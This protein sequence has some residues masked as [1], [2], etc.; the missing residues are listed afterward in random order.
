MASKNNV[1]SA[2]HAAFLE[3]LADLGHFQLLVRWQLRL[4]KDSVGRSLM[5]LEKQG[6]PNQFGAAN[7]MS[8]INL[9]H[10]GKLDIRAPYGKRVSEGAKLLPMTDEL[11]RR[12]N[13]FLLVRVFEKLEQHLQIMYGL[14]LYQLRGQVAVANK[15]GFHRR[16][17]KWKKQERTPQYF[18]AYAAFC[19]KHDEKAVLADFQKHVGWDRILYRSYHEMTWDEYIATLAFCRHR[20]VHNDGRVSMSSMKSLS[21]GQQ[22]YVL[23]CLNDSLYSKDKHLLPPT[24]L[25]DGLFEAVASYAWALYVLLSERCR[26]EDESQFFRS[27]DG[28]KRKVNPG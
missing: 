3:A 14:L 12:F 9:F 21:R 19:W 17:P 18:A 22:S 15:Q 6:L 20:I 23:E 5:V 8:I 16:H 26:M 7:G 27:E 2:E 13:S 11:E 10:D 24:R 4:A 28:G 1:F 25:I